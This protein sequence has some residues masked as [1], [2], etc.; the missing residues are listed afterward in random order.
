[1]LVDQLHA[2]FLSGCVKKGV[3]GLGRNA[4][5]VFKKEGQIKGDEEGCKT[6]D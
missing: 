6:K 2:C 4:F 3:G 5:G 1:M